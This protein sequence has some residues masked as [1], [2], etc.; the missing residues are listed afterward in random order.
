KD[1]YLPEQRPACKALPD[2]ACY[3]FHVPFFVTD[4]TCSALPISRGSVTDF[5]WISL[6]DDQQAFASTSFPGALPISRG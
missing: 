3:R 2:K 6:A 4:F 5:T 1:N